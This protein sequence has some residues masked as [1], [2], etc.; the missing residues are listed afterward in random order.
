[1][2]KNIDCCNEK[3]CKLEDEEQKEIKEEVNI[4]LYND[5]KEEENYID[6][7]DNSQWTNIIL[8][9]TISNQTRILVL[10][11]YFDFQELQ[12]RGNDTIEIINKITGIYQFSGSKIIENFLF[13]ICTESKISSFLKLECAKSLLSFEELEE[14]SDSDDDENLAQIKKES[15]IEVRERNEKR[16]KLGF[17]TLNTVCYNMS[18]MPTPCCIEAV[19]LLMSSDEYI[20]KC[21]EY[22]SC[23][24]SDEEIDCDF[25]YKILLSVEKQDNIKNK[26]LYLYNGLFCFLLNNKNKTMY[27]I[28]SAQ[29]LL[30]KLKITNDDKNEIEEI[31]LSFAN[32]NELDYDLRADSADLLLQLGSPEMKL[33]GREV[34]NLLAQLK[35]IVRTIFDNAQNVHNIDIENSVL[36]ILEFLANFPIM[37]NTNEKTIDYQYIFS[38]IDD[39]LKEYRNLPP[40]EIKSKH[41]CL[42]CDS[43][44]EIP[45]EINNNKFCCEI[46][47][48]NYI[49][50]NNIRISL[51]RI[52]MDR[53]LY[54]KFNLTL[55]HIL[56]KV[57]SYIMS[58]ENW[59]EMYN[60]LLEELQEMSGTCSSGFASRLVN[61][62][63]GFGEFNIRI[64]FTDQ[65]ISNFAGR[66]NS[67]IKKISDLNSIFLNERLNDMIEL[68]IISNSELYDEIK[69]KLQIPFTKGDIV[70]QYLINDRENK[71]MNCLAD[72]QLNVLNE[73]TIDSSDFNGRRNFLLFLRS[74]ISSIRTELYNEFKEY[75]SDTDFD[76]AF[77]RAI[78]NY[79]GCN[80]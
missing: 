1:M 39:T 70:N 18:D 38:K 69:S 27:R 29:Y 16:K 8:D 59:E 41:K 32:D 3:E 34:I 23:L 42:F 63:S 35:G 47:Y 65:I 78:Y 14:G 26:E 71:I 48:N 77:R 79:E 55:S 57:Y 37:K 15:D 24:L 11:K 43:P 50:E 52:Y 33:A 10:Q 61:V 72:F 53:L 5:E 22:L 46:C 56:I 28:L 67:R 51:N 6:I 80:Y 13:L 21:I 58:Q 76:L 4:E 19:F 75:V 17:Y 74:H 44:V 73:L 49:K 64:S 9:N 31:I 2:E 30:Q 54:S 40:L 62:I 60:R 25:R 20:E 36:H 66:L 12:Q 45:L 68:H 7:N